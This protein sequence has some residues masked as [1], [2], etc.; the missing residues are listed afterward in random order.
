MRDQKRSSFMAI[1]GMGVSLRRDVRRIAGV[2]ALS[3]VL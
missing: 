3:S 2:A 1:S